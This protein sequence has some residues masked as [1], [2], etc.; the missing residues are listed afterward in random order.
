M[1]LNK[2]IL[3]TDEPID[4]QVVVE[5]SDSSEES[6]NDGQQYN[7]I[8]I[9]NHFN[10]NSNKTGSS[11]DLSSKIESN[12]SKSNSMVLSKGSLNIIED[13]LY[14]IIENV[15]RQDNVNKQLSY[16]HSILNTRVNNMMKDCLQMDQKLTSLQNNTRKLNIALSNRY[17]FRIR[18]RKP[19]DLP[20]NNY[21][22]SSKENLEEMVCIL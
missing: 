20:T 3:L 6:D 2:P 19:L 1:S 11:N 5:I 4:H 12:D 17:K 14:N 15:L 9:D 18:H 16:T 22:S 13:E 8:E 7:S 21:S 10:N